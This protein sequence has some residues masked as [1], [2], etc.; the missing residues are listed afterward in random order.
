MVDVNNIEGLE[1][2]EDDYL[3][4]DDEPL[5]ELCPFLDDEGLVLMLRTLSLLHL[6]VNKMGK[7]PLFKVKCQHK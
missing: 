5:E 1:F 6:N 7:P 2:M 4:F 3:S